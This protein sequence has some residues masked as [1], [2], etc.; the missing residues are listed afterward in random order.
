MSDVDSVP[1]PF[2]LRDGDQVVFVDVQNAE[3]VLNFFIS[4]NF[5]EKV[6]TTTTIQ[7]TTRDS[8]FPAFDFTFPVEK[9]DKVELDSTE[10]RFVPAT[11]PVNDYKESYSYVDAHVTAGK[12]HTLKCEHDLVEMRGFGLHLKAM[13]GGVRFRLAMADTG[14]GAHFSGNY[15]PSNFEFDQFG[16][17]VTISIHGADDVKHVLYTNGKFLEKNGNHFV[18]QYPEEFTT[19]FPFLDLVPENR[20]LSDE[21]TYEQEKGEDVG[22]QVYTERSGGHDEGQLK[23]ILRNFLDT[24]KE[25]LRQLERDIGPYPYSNLVIHARKSGR[26]GMEYAGATSSSLPALTHEINHSYFARCIAPVNGNAGWMDEAIAE[27]SE[28]GYASRETPPRYGSNMGGR[29]EYIRATHVSS[30]TKGRDL[31]AWWRHK[32]RENYDLKTA[33]RGYFEEFKFGPSST[34]KFQEFLRD[35]FGNSIDEDFEQYVYD[36]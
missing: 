27:W 13:G 24:A 10:T 5:V 18:V 16:S 36:K 23:R 8:G 6:T 15:W 12:T 3:Y 35:R 31:L 1:K 30:Y 9:I 25:S 32:Y 17:K 14:Y 34:E 28:I 22:I 2:S 20:F 21:D 29:S 33:L 4:N 19:S 26:F 11:F 7:F